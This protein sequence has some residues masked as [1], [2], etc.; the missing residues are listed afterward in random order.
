MTRALPG[1]DRPGEG[2]FGME[3]TGASPPV[4]PDRHRADLTR[5]PLDHASTPADTHHCGA[6]TAGWSEISSEGAG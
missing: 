3:D 2:Y 1:Q 5:Q 4:V 6:W